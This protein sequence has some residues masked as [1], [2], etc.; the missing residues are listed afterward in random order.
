[1]IK[2]HETREVGVHC[3]AGG[4]GCVAGLGTAPVSLAM[5]P[6]QGLPPSCRLLLTSSHAGSRAC[7]LRGFAAAATPLTGDTEAWHCSRQA[8]WLCTVPWLP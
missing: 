8:S 5:A 3:V 1:M 7:P 6:G 4:L 2:V